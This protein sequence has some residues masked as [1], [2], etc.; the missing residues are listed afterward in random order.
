MTNRDKRVG[1]EGGVKAS[2]LGDAEVLTGKP[3]TWKQEG[4]ENKENEQ[5]EEKE[6]RKMIDKLID[7]RRRGNKVKVVLQKEEEKKEEE[8]R[9]E[10]RRGTEEERPTLE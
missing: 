9:V 7:L 6:G 4:K 5:R 1:C 3:R 2:T 8:P 10:Q